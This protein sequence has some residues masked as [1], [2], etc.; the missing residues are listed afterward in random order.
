MHEKRARIEAALQD[1]DN[2]FKRACARLRYHES[3]PVSPRKMMRGQL[4][5]TLM[6]VLIWN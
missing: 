1:S 6:A 2:Q 4:D 5:R 3:L